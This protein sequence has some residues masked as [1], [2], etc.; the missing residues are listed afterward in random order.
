[1]AIRGSDGE[2]G[3]RLACVCAGQPLL[4]RLHGTAANCRCL[5]T[6][7]IPYALMETLVFEHV[8]SARKE[9]VLSLLGASLLLTCTV[10]SVFLFDE[11]S[12]L[13]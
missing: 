2:H 8:R 12:I 5:R 7:E 9:G 10:V 11:I 6:G 3:D 4:P 13:V 1:M